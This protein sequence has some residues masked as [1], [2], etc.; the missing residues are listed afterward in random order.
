MPSMRYRGRPAR[1]DDIIDGLS[2]DRTNEGISGTVS[3]WLGVAEFE[4]DAL[5]PG[6]V[7]TP[8]AGGPVAANTPFTPFQGIWFL[9]LVCDYAGS[10]TVTLTGVR[11]DTGASETVAT[12]SLSAGETVRDANDRMDHASF[13]WSAT[14]SG[15]VTAR[16]F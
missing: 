4:A 7:A 14:G 3:Q 13:S 16:R 12:Y 8:V 15:N 9:Q 11:F 1:A 2:G 6:S 5:F 10:A